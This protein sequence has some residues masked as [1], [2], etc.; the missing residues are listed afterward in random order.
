MAL[1]MQRWNLHTRIALRIVVMTKGKPGLLLF[2]MM[3]VTWF[4]SMWIS[5]TATVMSMM[6]NVLAIANELESSLGKDRTHKFTLAMLIGVAFSASIGG[7]G[8]LIGT[9][10]NLALDAFL[11]QTFQNVGET[12]SF[13]TWFFFAFPLALVLFVILFLLFL[14]LFVPS[15]RNPLHIDLSDLKKKYQD[16][17]KISYEEIVVAICFVVLAILWMFRGDLKFGDN[18]KIP[19]WSNIFPESKFID[20]GTVAMIVSCLLYMIPAKNPCPVKGSKTFIMDW[21]TTKKIPWDI[22]FLFGGGYALSAAFDE[23]GLS[24]YIG[25][26]FSS[27]SNMSMPLLI[28][29]VVFVISL[30]TEVT[31]NTATS[32]VFIPIF[33]A[34]SKSLDKHPLILS[35]PVTISCS[36]AFSLPVAT[37][38]NL[39]VF[40]SKKITTKDMF[41]IGVI[42]HMIS[43]VVGTLLSIWYAP[44]IFGYSIDD[45]VPSNW[46]IPDSS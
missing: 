42:V 9:P 10:P 21:A 18:F 25:S 26:A 20:D 3:A 2:G 19:G 11:K 34:L 13:S 24:D 44:A 29:I 5:N 32:N 37:P 17:G 30:L 45:P 39:I 33:L 12:F 6:P 41:G 35:I 40:S 4:L 28:F 23:S 36:F 7:I 14:I 22:V 46:I 38:C 15:K 27:L 8:T 16:L 43:V 31:S 1:A